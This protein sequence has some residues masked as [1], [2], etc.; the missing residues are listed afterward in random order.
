M[1][2]PGADLYP[3][4][5][6]RGGLVPALQTKAASKGV[7]LGVVKSP[8]ASGPGWF[9]TAQMES[10]RGRITVELDGRSRAFHLGIQGQGFSW[11][12]G[13]TEDFDVLV[14]ALAAWRGGMRVDDFVAAFPFV[15]PGR[16]AKVH[17]SD[18]PASAQWEWLL[19]AEVYAEE[20]PLV[21]A[22][23]ADGRFRSLFP[24]LSH[25]TLRL[26][27]AG[28]RQG[29]REVR[30]TPLAGGGYRVE[31]TEGDVPRIA[32]SLPEAV[33]AAAAS[34]SGG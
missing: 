19:T 33:T 32:A 9:G 21:A 7:D 3:D 8:Y 11:A 26:N 30:I 16:Q 23:H 34:L 20:R 2:T 12:S 24:A 15:T 6:D 5:H 10:S 28:G 25:G 27:W 22:L 1:E 14:D 29:A 4:I 13:I 31:D 17:E 18:D